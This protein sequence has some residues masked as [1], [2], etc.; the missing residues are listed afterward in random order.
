MQANDPSRL[1]NS[2]LAGLVAITA[3]CNNVEM[4]AAA[5]IGVIGC[6]VYTG[7]TKLL[8]R[9]KIDDP[10]EAAQIH[11][12]SGFW[13][14]IAVG[15]FDLDEGLIYKGSF[16]QLQVQTL[17][18]VACAAWTM[19]FCYLFFTILASINRFRV[20]SFYEII[21]I[22]LLMHASVHDL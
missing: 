10:I 16:F 18:A 3:S 19:V 14:C 13:G 22:D 12:F 6:L 5:L 8:Y 20:S 9:F 4:W 21:G 17:G 11:G 15:I 2:I 7:S 1:M